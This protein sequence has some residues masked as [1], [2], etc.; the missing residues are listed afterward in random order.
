MST[1]VAD[2]SSSGAVVAEDA[3]V[4]QEYQGRTL[5]KR[6]GGGPSSGMTMVLDANSSASGWPD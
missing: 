2:D 5:R 4:E 3:E 6:R 1:K